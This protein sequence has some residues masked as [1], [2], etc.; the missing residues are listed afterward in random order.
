[1]SASSLCFGDI[2]RTGLEAYEA[3]F[4]LTYIDPQTPVAET[5]SLGQYRTDLLTLQE[6]CTLKQYNTM[7]SLA[8]LQRERDLEEKRRRLNLQLSNCTTRSPLSGVLKHYKR[9]R[10]QTAKKYDSCILRSRASSPGEAASAP[11]RH[12]ASESQPEPISE[13]LSHL[14]TASSSPTRWRQVFPPSRLSHLHESSP[15]D[16]YHP[17]LMT[18]SLHSYH[19]TFLQRAR[20]RQGGTQ[21]SSLL[22]PPVGQHSNDYIYVMNHIAP[23]IRYHSWRSKHPLSDTGNIK[24]STPIT[25]LSNELTNKSAVSPVAQTAQENSRWNSPRKVVSSLSTTRLPQLSNRRRKASP[26]LSPMHPVAQNLPTDSA[27]V[28]TVK[29]ID[30]GDLKLEDLALPN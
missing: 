25:Q 24:A 1:M 14:P 6:K 29:A 20:L 27:D 26:G 9:E 5:E 8:K 21:S 16:A 19:Q 4:P 30:L 15:T 10:I 7:E 12:F 13:C 2:D 3:G 28:L 23:D 22:S 18:R 17:Y 11:E